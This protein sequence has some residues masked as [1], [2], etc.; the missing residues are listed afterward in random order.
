MTKSTRLSLSQA[1]C[2]T[3]DETRMTKD[4]VSILTP[5]TISR[6]GVAVTS[7]ERRFRKW[8]A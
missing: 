8:L 4:H 2:R 1:E 6:Y 3:N 5:F 7:V